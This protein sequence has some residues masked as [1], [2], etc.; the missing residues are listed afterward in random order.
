[1]PHLIL[2]HSANLAGAVRSLDLVARVHE[3]ALETGVFPLGGT[4]TRALCCDEASVADRDPENGFIDLEVRIG[5]GRDTETKKRVGEA[6]F[7]VLVDALGSSERGPHTALSLEIREIDPEL[8]WRH[9][10]IHERVKERQQ[11]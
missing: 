6:I 5:R 4:R 1:M 7:S 3:A 10:P 9:N 8:A 11:R 2:Q